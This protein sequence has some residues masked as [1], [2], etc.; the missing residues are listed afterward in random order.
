MP[1]WMQA[2]RVTPLTRNSSRGCVEVVD[3]S[4]CLSIVFTHVD[5]QVLTTADLLYRSRVS[6]RFS[7][8]D[9]SSIWFRQHSNFKLSGLAL[10]QSR[11]GVRMWAVR[12]EYGTL[13]LWN[14][15]GKCL[16]E[17]WH[18]PEFVTH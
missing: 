6:V 14:R 10:G 11:F 16:H 4:A 9:F 8:Q 1:G 15:G 17:L 7:I 18:N 12:T 13:G 2:L 5:L 3:K